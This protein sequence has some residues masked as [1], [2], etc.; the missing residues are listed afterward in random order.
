[1]LYAPTRISRFTRGLPDLIE[2]QLRVDARYTRG[3]GRGGVFKIG[4]GQL[5]I[6]TPLA[7]VK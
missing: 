4:V 5:R 7:G 1:M 2:I 3:E 6:S